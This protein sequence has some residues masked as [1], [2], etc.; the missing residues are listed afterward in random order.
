MEK[1]KGVDLLKIHCDKYIEVTKKIIK[2]LQEDN[3]EKATDLVEERE[4]LI[5]D[6]KSL[7]YAR[8][9]FIEIFNK[10]ELID[11]ENK[12]VSLIKEKLQYAKEKLGE[13]KTSKTV[14]NNYNKY[15]NKSFAFLN[16]KV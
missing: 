11:L 9:E 13:L 5:E 8:E 16:K 2:F 7:D 15:G 10:K 1:I 14:N 4:K 12:C 3:L 6:I